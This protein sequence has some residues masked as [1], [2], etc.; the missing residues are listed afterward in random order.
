MLKKRKGWS[1]IISTLIVIMI[2]LMLFEAFYIRYRIRYTVKRYDNL[3]KN[4]ADA[5]YFINKYSGN[6][7]LVPILSSLHVSAFSYNNKI[8]IIVKI[9]LF[10][11]IYLIYNININISDISNSSS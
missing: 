9:K 3:I 5:V 7:T 2:I 8:N 10:A 4:Y 6:K 11:N 1:I